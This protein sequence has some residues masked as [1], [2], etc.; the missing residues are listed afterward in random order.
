MEVDSVKETF[1]VHVEKGYVEELP[2]DAPCFDYGRAQVVAGDLDSL[3]VG[4]NVELVYLVPASE[5]IIVE[6]LYIG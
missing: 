6:E 3:E 1:R 2:S 5:P 4:S